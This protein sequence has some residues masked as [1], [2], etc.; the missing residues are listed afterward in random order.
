VGVIKRQGLKNIFITYVGVIIGAISTLYIQPEL[1]SLS[2]LGFTRN[3]YNFS[4]LLSIAIPLGLPNIILKFYP[5]FKQKETFKKYFLGF[6]LIY[7]FLATIITVTAFYF[8]KHYILHLYSSQSQLFIS[9][10]FCVIP[11]SLIIAFN[12]CI[13]CF[14]QSVYKSTV[15][16]FLNDVLSRL[17]VI[18]ITILYYY[19]VISFNQYV[20]LYVLIYLLVTFIL[21][22]YLSNYGLI[23]FKIKLSIFKTIGLKKI[24]YYGL[25]LCVISFASFGL[26]SIDS[27]FLGFYS[28]NSVAIYT[29]AAF[30]AMFIEVPLGA[31]D[32]ISL[33]KISENFLKNNLD[34]IAKIYSESVKYLLVLG[35]FL[36]L[37]INTCS[38]FVF[39]FLPPEYSNS[40]DI[41][42]I[43]SFGSLVN[44]STGINSSI[45][46]YSHH[47]K[48][49]CI[50][51]LAIFILTVILDIL[52]IPVFGT[53][54]A[55]IITATVSIIF[56]LSKFLFIYY[57]FKFLPYTMSS[58]KIVGVI[59][60][61]FIIAW[62]MPTFT[63]YNILNIFI[64]GSLIS[65]FYIGSIYKLN[66]IPEMFEMAK[67][68][69]SK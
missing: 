18:A 55:A 11:L 33:S 23:S 51:L 15:P 10:F 48:Q 28:L 32:R 35:G 62:F 40:L 6:I 65:L 13:T 3:L 7:F 59:V 1:L 47:Y 67:S 42:L 49:G 50:L 2:E 68:K 17:I 8:F 38:K 31:I 56:N 69:I 26:R 53:K 57:K 19:K 12:S 25:F 43:L 52:F 24:I 46:F 9:Y 16:S 4:F 41:L 27:I 22:G 36:F 29:T 54:G 58:F 63:Q 5:E 21:I 34:E 39:T 60:V 45:L 66:V 37:G 44:V 30:L 64:N 14:S 61:G 20:A